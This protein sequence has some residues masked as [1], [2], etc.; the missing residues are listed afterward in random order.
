[1]K[2]ALKFIIP[3]AIMGLLIS[4]QFA[5]GTFGVEV[6]N[7]FTYDIIK[8]NISATIGTNS[9]SAVGYEVDG[10]VFGEGTQVDVEV[11]NVGVSSV[12]YEIQ[13]GSY[14]ITETSS[15]LDLAFTTLLSIL[16]PLAAIM[17]VDQ[18]WNQTEVEEVDE[19]FIIPFVENETTTW[20]SYKD[21]ADDLQ[22]SPPVSTDTL[23]V[24]GINATYTETVTEFVFE[25]YFFGQL[26]MNDTLITDYYE[27]DADLEHHFQFAFTKSTGVLLGM[28]MQGSVVG[29]SN[30]TDIDFSYY[31]H[32]E[33]VGYNLPN[34]IYGGGGGFIPGFEWFIAIPALAFIG[35][36]AV[37]VRRRK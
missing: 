33:K 8:S 28:R 36:I 27:V 24:V 37:I 29:I 16:A 2:K 18:T 35:T 20:D 12:E 17:I 21:L 34:Y 26:V 11:T 14:F 9:G 6:G 15:S 5:N 30:A 13:A 3:I 32:V 4:T 1:L 10:Q 25:L 23:G 19:P 7:T 31:Y 22:T